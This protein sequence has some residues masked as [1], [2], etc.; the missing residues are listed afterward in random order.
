MI[1]LIFQRHE[2]HNT[3]P[4]P[5]C[6][7]TWKRTCDLVLTTLCDALGGMVPVTPPNAPPGGPMDTPLGWPKLPM[8]GTGGRP[9][10]ATGRLKLDVE[11]IWGT[12]LVLVIAITRGFIVDSQ[13]TV[14]F[15]T[16]YFF[17]G[18]YF[19]T[20]P[21]LSYT[22]TGTPVRHPRLPFLKQQ[23]STSPPRPC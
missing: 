14:L 15:C 19:L 3:T 12:G 20:I 1:R 5:T 23:V 8:D 18:Y 21:Q 7:C 17:K 10:G 9:E 13:H 16:F 11:A 6:G 22:R 4:V 2:N